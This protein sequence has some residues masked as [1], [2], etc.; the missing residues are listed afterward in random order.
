MARFEFRIAD[1]SELFLLLGCAGD[2]DTGGGLCLFDGQNLEVIDRA[3]TAGLTVF[4]GCL[5]RLLRTPLMTGGGEILIY[6]R[7]G[8]SHYLRIDELSD[9]HYMAWDGTHL[10]TTSTGSNELLWIT[11][12]GQVARRWS[13]PGEGDSWHLN[14][15]CMAGHRLYACA[16]GKYTHYRDYKAHLSKGDGFIF[17]VDSGRV[18]ASGF[19]APHSPRYFDDA[20][21]VCESFR[22]SVVQVEAV[23]G[24]RMREVKLNSF[25]R[26]MAITDDYLIVGESGF[27][28][29]GAGQPTTG[30]VAILRRS[31]FSFLMR[32]E[33]PFREVSEIAV[34]SR[35]LV[36]G[37][38]TGFRT[39]SLR[40]AERDQLQMFCDVGI[41]P[42]RLWAV[43]EPLTAGQCR[44]RVDAN[45]PDQFVSGKTTLVEC[46]VQNLGDGFLC[47][48]LPHP[49]NLS[50]RWRGV[51][52]PATLDAGDGIRTHL[53]SMLPPG[54]A[55][56]C[57]VEVR[58]P[59]AEGDYELVLTMVQEGVTWFNDID[60]TNACCAKVKAIRA[61]STSM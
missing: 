60:A 27:R 53:P 54:S 41:Q 48:H 14:D 22:H 44:I 11:L 2:Q 32:F 43:S 47:S 21:T 52:D 20:W 39:N 51:G 49:V 36:N 42:T 30:T 37:V 35:A 33:L 1:E 13:A 15:V 17:D 26:G 25:T 16:F 19:C 9:A 18:L 12:S 57:R 61:E 6:D 50:Y 40:T 8:I 45:I 59:D 4:D 7:R 34:V 55:I 3:S 24:R 56:T 46:H 5:A 10:I 23:S 38:K 29:S 31:D 58:A 28:T